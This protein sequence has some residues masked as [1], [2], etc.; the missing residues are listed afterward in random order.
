MPEA[1]GGEAQRRVDRIQA[2]RDELVELESALGPVLEPAA[3]A[4]VA[5]H[6]DRVL[7]RLKG[8]FDIDATETERQLSLGMRVASLLGAFAFCVAVFLFFYRHWGRIVFPAQIA[9]LATGPVLGL[10]LTAYAARR[11][12]SLYFA[13]LAGMVTCASLVLALEALGRILSLPTSPWRFLAWALFG[14]ALARIYR[15]R[16][17]YAAAVVSLSIFLL[18][19]LTGLSGAW[20][21]GFVSRPEGF[22]LLGM[23]WVALPLARPGLV[24]GDFAPT[25]RLTGA[26]MAFVALLA[27]GLNGNLSLLPIDRGALEAIYDVVALTAGAGG[28][29]LGIRRGWHEL[30]LV[31]TVYV[32]VLLVVKAFDW[33]WEWLPRELFFLVLGL[34]A[35]GTLLLLRRVRTR[36]A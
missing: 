1:R 36:I 9:L 34:L 32:I 25:L 10:A 24:G 21:T 14:L 27:L 19:G 18:G 13:L 12:R 5:E 26:L 6:H 22:A 29:A 20:W 4:R 7:E 3:R 8:A 23:G 15:F 2:F 16:L 17:V 31:S 11:E 30:R 33:W 35:I 28:I